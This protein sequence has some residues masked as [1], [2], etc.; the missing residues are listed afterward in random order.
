M[1]PPIFEWFGSTGHH[2]TVSWNIKHGRVGQ[3]RPMKYHLL[4]EWVGRSPGCGRSISLEES[5]AMFGSSDE[6]GEVPGRKAA[7]E[8]LVGRK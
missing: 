7:R 3:L 8:E 4:S 5:I 6:R 2:W 1:D